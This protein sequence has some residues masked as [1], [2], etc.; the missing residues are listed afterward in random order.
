MRLGIL[1]NSEQHLPAIIGIT[2]TAAAG[3]HQVE[4]F[5][6][7]TGTRLLERP[8][9]VALAELAGVTMSFCDHSAKALG[10]ATTTLSEKIVCSS[11]FSNAKMNHHADR[12][13]TL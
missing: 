10:V 11:Q 4:I 5:A 7:D 1:V 6:M 3:G 9:Y 12:V 8:D 13:I 2:H